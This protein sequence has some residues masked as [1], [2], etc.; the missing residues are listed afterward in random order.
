MAIAD[1]PLQTCSFSL[2]PYFTALN[3]TDGDE[4]LQYFNHS[5]NILPNTHCQQGSTHSNHATTLQHHLA[6]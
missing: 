2:L 4:L 5:W 6:M 1:F 3:Y